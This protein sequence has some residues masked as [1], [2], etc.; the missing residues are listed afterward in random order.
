MWCNKGGLHM[1][2]RENTVEHISFVFSLLPASSLVTRGSVTWNLSASFFQTSLAGPSLSCFSDI[3]IHYTSL[4]C[5][6]KLVSLIRVLIDKHTKKMWKLGIEQR[7][8]Q[9][10][11][12]QK[13]LLPIFFSYFEV[14]RKIVKD[15]KFP[16]HILLLH[17]SGSPGLPYQKILV[18]N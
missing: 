3:H 9:I 15:C 17:C 7:S 2:E 11:K 14:V 18:C 13:P 4:S 1:S 5:Y 12:M 8:Q 16:K 10:S 6:H